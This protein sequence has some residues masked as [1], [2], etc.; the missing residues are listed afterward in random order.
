M[1]RPQAEKTPGNHHAPSA[2]GRLSGGPGGWAESLAL[3]ERV[4]RCACA[5][6]TA[7]QALEA[8]AAALSPHL[9]H[10]WAWLAEA[11]E[12][13][14]EVAVTARWPHGLCPATMPGRLPAGTTLIRL[15]A[16]RVAGR[17]WGG[18]GPDGAADPY[19]RAL[20][21]LGITSHLTFA[22]PAPASRGRLLTLVTEEGQPFEAH[23]VALARELSGA[24]VAAFSVPMSDHEAAAR[25]AAR[26]DPVE[27][28]D[29]VCG[30][31]TH[32]VRNIVSGILGAIELGRVGSP[33]GRDAVLDAVR[34]RALEAVGMMEA[35]NQR[36]LSSV[37]DTLAP[38]DLHQVARE[39]SDLVQ[40]ALKG[41]AER[42]PPVRLTCSGQAA[43]ARGDR[44]ELRRAAAALCFNAACASAAGGPVYVT[45]GTEG[46]HA[47]L[48]VSDRGEGMLDDV[49]RRAKEPF[50]TTRHGDH[51]GLGLTIAEG[52]ARRSGG[53]L[54]LKRNDGRGITA[55]LALPLSRN[56]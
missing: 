51:L 41:T 7:S 30:A 34:R 3:R 32:D 40:K 29:Y 47:V 10:R 8:V 18:E 49:L 23:H 52:V 21:D 37:P 53:S 43:P 24:V 35:M 14:D 25:R 36:L 54:R 26:M 13:W 2:V 48:A 15:R 9:P 44:R 5:A 17:A 55:T 16:G 1:R 46:R 33:E 12:S 28:L 38:V 56:D 50:Y 27:I 42:R 6:A 39:V 20:A 11:R 4:L 22:L 31:V 19:D 45:A